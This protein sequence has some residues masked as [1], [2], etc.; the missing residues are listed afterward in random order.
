MNIRKHKIHLRNKQNLKIRLE[1]NVSHFFT[2]FLSL[3][4]Y[5]HMPI[6]TAPLVNLLDVFRMCSAPI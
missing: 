3:L 2:E 4:L 5:R 6:P 1:S